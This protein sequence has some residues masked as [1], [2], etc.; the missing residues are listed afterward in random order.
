MVVE[1]YGKKS[2]ATN[3][4]NIAKLRLLSY[5]SIPAQLTRRDLGGEEVEGEVNEMDLSEGLCEVE[6][7]VFVTRPG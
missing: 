5:F 4:A 2:D 3:A 1:R 6:E 7:V